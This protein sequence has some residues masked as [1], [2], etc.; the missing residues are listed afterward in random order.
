MPFVEIGLVSDTF[1]LSK[2]FNMSSSKEKDLELECHYLSQALSKLKPN[3]SEWSFLQQKLE[4]AKEE[5]DMM[6]AY[7]PPPPPSTLKHPSPYLDDSGKIY[8]T[9]TS[10]GMYYRDNDPYTNNI[11]YVDDPDEYHDDRYNTSSSAIDNDRSALYPSS[12]NNSMP[13]TRPCSHVASP[14]ICTNMRKRLLASILFVTVVA[15]VITFP[16]LMTKRD[17]STNSLATNQDDSIESPTVITEPCASFSFHMIP[18][19]FGNE[20]SWMIVKYNDDEEIPIEKGGPYSYTKAFDNGSTGDHYEMVHS[21]TCLSVGKYA[22]ILYDA[23]EDGICCQYGRGEYG[24]NLSKG[25]TIR[26]LSPGDFDGTEEITPF[27]VSEDD[28]DVLPEILSLPDNIISES[29]DD[30]DE[31]DL[32][33]DGVLDTITGEDSITTPCA[34]WSMHLI[35]D[36]FGVSELFLFTLSCIKTLIYRLLYLPSRL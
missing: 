10:S 33:L 17:G 1:I 19:Q 5:L 2:Q 7:P 32:P 34:S 13:S 14:G 6:R 30:D 21:T 22:F 18:D 15:I 9:S 4:V 20:T 35:P 23:K 36:Q 29:G 31:S 3:S 8:N 28:I 12:P 26:P 24:I 11:P 16:L 25:K 27:T